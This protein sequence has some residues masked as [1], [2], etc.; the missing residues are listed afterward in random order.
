M[1]SAFLQGAAVV[2]VTPTLTVH[3]VKAAVALNVGTVVIALVSA[4]PWMLTAMVQSVVRVRVHGDAAV[5]TT[6][7]AQLA[8]TVVTELA[9]AMEAAI[10]LSAATVNRLC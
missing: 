3:P 7:N 9:Q 8:N 5:H 10:T 1:K 4:V 2:S 6:P